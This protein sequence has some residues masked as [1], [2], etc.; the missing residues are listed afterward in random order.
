[1]SRVKKESLRELSKQEEQALEK[2]AKSTSERVDTV[3]RARALL[4]VRAGKSY[5]DAAKEAGYKSNDS[6]SQLVSRFNQHGPSAL[7]IAAGRGRK[8]TYSSADQLRILKEVQREPDRQEDQTAT[9]SL[10][11]LQQSLR[12]QELPRVSQ[13]T[14]RQILH[15]S[16][17]SYQR[18]RTWCRTGY[19]ERKRKSGTVTVY[20]EQT[21]EK[22][23]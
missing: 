18:T 10:S 19:A 9:W 4:L 16:G 2:L 5:T 14:I 21:P 12:K 20:D 8:P 22:K 15:E 13:E 7:A 17:Y 1:M 11:T 23:D 3:K 6:V